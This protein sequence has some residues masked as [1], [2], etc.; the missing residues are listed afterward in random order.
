M[1]EKKVEKGN[2]I[3][4]FALDKKDQKGILCNT[5]ERT[6]EFYIA[7]YT[8]QQPNHKIVFGS[9]KDPS[10][11][12]PLYGEDYLLDFKYETTNPHDP[13]AI[14]ISI[15][16]DKKPRIFLGYVPKVLS[17]H[18][19][20]E[21][22]RVSDWAVYRVRSGFLD[23][24]YYSTKVI[25]GYDGKLLLPIDTAISIERFSDIE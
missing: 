2:A 11:I 9:A 17:V 7:G 23:K 18:L 12:Y 14:A 3:I 13:N 21:F 22:N 1:A 16:I 10:K 4:P 15:E 25:L 24:G 6:L 5:I 20:K 19:K 8:Y